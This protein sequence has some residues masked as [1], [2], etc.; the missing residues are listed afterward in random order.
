LSRKLGNLGWENI[1]WKITEE[2][3]RELAHRLLDR[4][5][6]RVR[7]NHLVGGLAIGV[8]QAGLAIFSALLYVWCRLIAPVNIGIAFH[9]PFYA[10]VA[11][12]LTVSWVIIVFSI[13]A[14]GSVI[15]IGNGINSF[16]P[17]SDAAKL[18]RRIPL[19]RLYVLKP[20]KHAILIKRPPYIVAS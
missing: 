9:S 2:A 1:A 6:E 18:V 7:R 8:G 17:D 10:G 12:F 15:L 19:L 14:F 20:R 13:G 5:F 16:D 11:L 4:I 3:A